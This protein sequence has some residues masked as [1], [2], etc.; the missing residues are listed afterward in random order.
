MG[1]R[2][3]AGDDRLRGDDGGEGR[4]HHENDDVVLRHQLEEDLMHDSGI[5][6]DERALAEIVEQ[7]ARHDEAQPADAD[8]F[9]A[10]MAHVGIQGFGA[11]DG[12]HDRAEGPENAKALVGDEIVGVDRI[13]GRQDGR[14]LDH[15]PDAENAQH[16]EP[17]QHHRSEQAADIGGAAG[18]QHE[19]GDEDDQR[20]RQDIRRQGG[21]GRGQALDGAH[22]GD[23]GCDDRVAVEQGQPDH[24]QHHDRLADLL[25]LAV[26]PAGRERRQRQNAAFALVVGAHDQHDVFDGDGQRH[27]PEQHRE[28][29]QH[30]L[31]R[32]R[33][34]AAMEEGLAQ[35]IE[36]AGADIAEHDTERPQNQGRAHGM[37]GV[38]V[39]CGGFGR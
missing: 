31:A 15:L 11:G 29:A 2:E 7:Q 21:L 5:L 18:L 38:L 28:H 16:Q 8:R 9:A 33:H 34:S 22:H 19:Q 4:E 1:Q 30:M 26:Q 13:D 35:R 6:D 23:G 17:D 32:R 39:T 24:R 3:H 14:V 25:C 20:Q 12:Q 27:R 10:K 37:G 36:R